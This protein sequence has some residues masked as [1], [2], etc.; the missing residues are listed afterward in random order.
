MGDAMRDQ[1][2]QYTGE[3]TATLLE[4]EWEVRWTYTGRG[5]AAVEA[6]EFEAEK[7]VGRER[8]VFGQAIS[9]RELLLHR[10]GARDLAELHAR[11]AKESLKAEIA[12]GESRD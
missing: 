8:F 6:V 5:G 12:R 9:V 4:A 2:R 7:R 1:V 3:V 11:D 10:L